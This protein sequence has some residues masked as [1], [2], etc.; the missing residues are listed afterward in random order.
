LVRTLSGAPRDLRCWT[1][2][3][4]PSPLAFW[5]RR[6]VHETAI[7]RVDAQVAAGQPITS[8]ASRFAADGIDELLTGLFGREAPDP[9]TGE[10]V[11]IIGFEP[12]D[13]TAGWTVRILA[14]RLEAAPG[15]GPCDVT[16]RASAEVLYLLLWNRRSEAGLD[17]TGRVE[18]L[19]T[20][21][22]RCRVTWS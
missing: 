14:N 7:H 3:A 4:A 10:V 21:R 20:W 18:L 12:T 8:I 1:F 17:L 19:E 13:W 6:Q 11:G 9:P 22:D 16:I 5:A 2:L 15:L